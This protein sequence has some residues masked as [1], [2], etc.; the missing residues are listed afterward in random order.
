VSDLLRAARLA[1]VAEQSMAAMPREA[2]AERAQWCEQTGD[3]GVHVQE[4]GGLVELW[5]GGQLL[6]MLEPEALGE[7]ALT[8]RM[9]DMREIPGV[10]SSQPSGPHE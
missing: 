6:A 5:W 3:R 10:D 9:I 7:E 1:Y 8:R 2:F 4:R